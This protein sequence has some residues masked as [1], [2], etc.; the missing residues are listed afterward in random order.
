MAIKRF[1]FHKRILFK[2]LFPV[3]V[4]GVICST[5]LVRV[6]SSPLEDFLVRQFDA[7]LAQTA[8]MGLQVCQDSLS[9]LLDLRLEGN[10]EMNQAMQMEAMNRITSI[11]D[12]FPHIHLMILKP[13]EGIQACSLGMPE[14]DLKSS[15]IY[16]QTDGVAGFSLMG[17]TVRASSHFFPF[18][19]WHIVSFVF[20]QDYYSPVRMAHKIV[21]LSAACVFITILG[22]L[23]LAF[24]LLIKKPL[25]QLIEAT[26]GVAEGRFQKL[27]TINEQEFGLLML[28]FNEMVD[29]LEREKA[30]VSSLI[31][32]LKE[33]EA[34]FR[35]QFEFG[36][37]GIAITSV[38]DGWVKVNARLCEILGYSEQEL[39][40]V[41]W[42][43]LTHPEDLP[44]EMEPFNRM[45]AG[46]LDNYE[47]EKRVYHKN[48]EL[49]FVHL[50][51]SC[52]RNPDQSV[53]FIIVSLLN[54]TERKRA[55]ESQVRNA[56]F[57]RALLN[58]V[59]TPVFYKDKGG[60]YQGCNRAFCDFMGVSV[61]QIMGKRVN[62]LWPSDQ[63]DMYHRKDLELI[64]NPIHQVYEFEVIDKDGQMRPVIFAK[65]V[66]RDESGDVAG[67]IGAFSDI[68]RL[69]AAENA[70][71]ET[72]RIL[73]LVLD[74]IPVRVFWKDRD[75]V[76]QGANLAFARDAGLDST[77]LLVGKTDFDL[78]FESQAE[79]F[80]GDD[81]AVM[82]SGEDKLFYEEPQD[83]PD[84]ATNWLLTSKVPMRDENQNV[85]GVLGAYQ[86]ITDR[87]KAEEEIRNLR[88][89][90][91]NIINSMPSVLIGVDTDGRITQ[92]NNEAHALTG[93]S[94]VS[95]MGK[96]LE[97][98]FPRLS[99]QM[100]LVRDAI[101]SKQVRYSPRQVRQV[102]RFE[103]YEDVT[104]YPLTANGVEG[105][106]IRV[107]DVT[108]KARLEEM[109]V[110]SEKMLS[111]GGLA[112]GM[113]HEINNPLAGMIQNANVM[114]SRLENLD[115]KAN[116]RV[117][118][119]IGIPMDKIRAFMEKR[120]IFNMVAAINESGQRVADIVDNML[121]FARK[122]EAVVSS[123]HPG[124][125]LDLVLELATTDYD[126][127]KQ[128]D[129]KAIKII[130]E[131]EKDLPMIPCEGS[132]IQQVLLNILRNGAFAMQEQGTWDGAPPCFILRLFVE[133]PGNMLRIEI[134]DNGPGMDKKI[135][136]RIFEPFFTTK[137][138]GTGT[139]L[140]LSVSYFI[141]KENHAGTMDVLSAP[142][143]GSTFI[144]RLPLQKGQDNN[145]TG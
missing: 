29:S 53:R 113:A 44:A 32:Q 54:I 60:R 38:Q 84:G 48:G 65:D 31:R 137:L 95:A 22:T 112:A 81:Q 124:E 135:Q 21:Y 18:W 145:E 39:Q 127:K 12:K 52:F 23:L 105:A 138:P 133:T 139:G 68:T 47:L 40:E 50:S 144:I 119:E 94:L 86:D 96:R 43:E 101:E 72:S 46:E 103:G 77:D 136:Q 120:S 4:V 111:V 141:I 2:L 128:Y 117:A 142:G 15:P 66:F 30:E 122:S 13:G 45:I 5:L 108:E 131:Y 83:R 35:S 16:D 59:P 100:T 69:K 26:D 73:R 63:A 57:I 123:H 37:I 7:N 33:S 121:S 116:L 67:I 10:A 75:C 20:E 114:R 140:G 9:Y 14:G 62:E 99:K 90:L 58:A 91:S 92:W 25:N 49:L 97:H 24:H 71:K 27:D 70:H 11:S 61:E 41:N 3:V 143:K 98:V 51:A 110:Q 106:V 74:S 129:F 56:N 36:N 28:S 118:E 89:Y 93:I 8:D 115:M 88:N 102:D 1:P 126:L 64:E 125:L 104:I 76:Y 130:K 78:A 132:K 107:D 19:D 79:K 134:E 87:K 82:A 55:I 80:R 109:M 34:L 42:P 17:K 6:L 85:I